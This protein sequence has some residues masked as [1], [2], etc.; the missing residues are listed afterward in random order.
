[1]CVIAFSP[2]GNEAPT[3]KQIKEMFKKNPD[4]AGYAWDDGT[5]VHFKKGFMNVD[6][7]IEDLGPLEKWKD[8]NLAM[9]FRIGTAGKNDKKTTHPFPL[10][11]NF[12]ELRKLQ[13][14]GPVLFHNGVISGYGGIIDPLASDTQDFV[15]G[16][17]SKLL[18]RPNTPSKITAKTISTIIGSSRLLIMYGKNRVV[19]FG[20]W[21]EKNGNYYSNLLWEP[22]KYNYS[23]SYPTYY[24]TCGTYYDNTEPKVSDYAWPSMYHQWIK[25]TPKRGQEILAQ[26]KE[27]NG[28]YKFSTTKELEWKTNEDYTEWWTTTVGR[29]LKL[30]YEGYDNEDPDS[31]ADL[32]ET[33]YMTFNTEQE[34]AQWASQGTVFNDHTVEIYGVTW[35]MDDVTLEAFTKNVAALLSYASD[36]DDALEVLRETGHL[37]QDDDELWDMVC[38]NK[39]EDKIRTIV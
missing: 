39:L 2:K 18:T 16:V 20:D 33:D 24:G 37:P 31:Y 26:A 8:K 27:E 36:I 22:C 25:V 12:G 3:E 32:F 35:Y 38:E 13:G 15:A 23:T 34:M 30:E 6:D 4:G 9:H 19:K 10:T 11:N 17:A 1:M 21:K 14:D 28:F 5:T 7:L 29:Q